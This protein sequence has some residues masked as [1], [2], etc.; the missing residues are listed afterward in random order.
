MSASAREKRQERKVP[1]S[2]HTAPLAHVLAFL[3]ALVLCSQAPTCHLTRRTLLHQTGEPPRAPRPVSS[4]SSSVALSPHKVNVH[5]PFH[6]Y[7]SSQRQRRTYDPLPFP[8]GA[9]RGGRTFTHPFLFGCAELTYWCRALRPCRVY[10]TDALVP[11]IGVPADLQ[12]NPKSALHP[13]S[14]GNFEVWAGA[15]TD[16]R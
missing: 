7:R 3:H 16:A 9:R 2:T 4:S 14:A 1:R 15:E 6:R 11:L 12:S 13:A 10:T 5:L 8:P